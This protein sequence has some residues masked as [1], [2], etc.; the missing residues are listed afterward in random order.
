MAT[1]RHVEAEGLCEAVARVGR[2]QFQDYYDPHVVTSGAK[3]TNKGAAFIA[4][5]KRCATP[6]RIPVKGLNS[7]G[8]GALDST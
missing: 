1:R 2:E 5:L 8:L 4:A 3:A 6:N 7:L